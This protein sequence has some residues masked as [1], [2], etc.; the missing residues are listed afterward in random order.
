MNND[1]KRACR[2]HSI[3]NYMLVVPGTWQCAKVEYKSVLYKDGNS[4][5]VVLTGLAK[6]YNYL[7]AYT[8][9]PVPRSYHFWDVFCITISSCPLGFALNN[10]TQICRCGLILKLVVPSAESWNI[11]AQTILRPAGN[12][13]TGNINAENYYTYQV[14]SHCPFDYCLSHTSTSPILTI[15]VSLT[16]LVCCV[17]DVKKVLVL[18][19]VLLSVKNAPVTICFS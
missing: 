10:V 12:W 1:C 13:I 3:K 5:N 15:S 16:G 17:E 2:S 18:C 14:S 9:K 4:C 11:D 8:E 6:T 7:S 19:L